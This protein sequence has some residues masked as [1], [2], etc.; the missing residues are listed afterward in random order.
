MMQHPLLCLFIGTVYGSISPC[1]K[2]ILVFSCIHYKSVKIVCRSGTGCRRCHLLLCC[3]LLLYFGLG[4][5]VTG[6][7][8]L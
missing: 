7:G 8:G 5:I 4:V 3:C 6:V 1:I 2:E